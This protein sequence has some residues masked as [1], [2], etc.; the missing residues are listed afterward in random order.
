MELIESSIEPF[1]LGNRIYIYILNLTMLND[2][3]FTNFILNGGVCDTGFGTCPIISKPYPQIFVRCGHRSVWCSND[4]LVVSMIQRSQRYQE[5]KLPEPE[6]VFL[7]VRSK[8][9]NQ[10]TTSGAPSAAPSPRGLEIYRRWMGWDDPHEGIRLMVSC[11]KVGLIPATYGP[12]IC[13]DSPVDF[14]IHPILGNFPEIFWEIFRKSLA[15]FFTTAFR[16]SGRLCFWKFLFSVFQRGP[17]FRMS[18]APE[19]RCLQG[20]WQVQPG[21]ELRGRCWWAGHLKAE[22]IDTNGPTGT[23]FLAQTG[24][25][26]D[27][28]SHQFCGS[29]VKR[30]SWLK[31]SGKTVDTELEWLTLLPV[32]LGIYMD[33][34]THYVWIHIPVWMTINPIHPYTMFW[35]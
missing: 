25:D 10:M 12:K 1:R 35:P 4:A 14:G 24:M 32:M 21:R 19:V 18:G 5:P 31:L 20:L 13:R 9:S 11:L 22:S 30:H 2:R 23:K 27:P 16:C 26:W 8:G 7:L 34:H 17:T 29:L 3:S 33:L 15:L 6:D 28:K